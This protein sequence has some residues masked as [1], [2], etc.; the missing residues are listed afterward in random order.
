MVFRFKG[1]TTVQLI[2]EHSFGYKIFTLNSELEISGHTIKRKLLISDSWICVLSTF[3]LILAPCFCSNSRS[4]KKMCGTTNMT[5]SHT[6]LFRGLLHFHSSLFLNYNLLFHSAFHLDLF[7]DHNFLLGSFLDGSG[8][9][10]LYVVSRNIA[11][12]FG[13]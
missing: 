8:F 7:R 10:L 3:F 2:R 4:K 9:N 1:V 12:F 11:S 6:F 13:C 5:I